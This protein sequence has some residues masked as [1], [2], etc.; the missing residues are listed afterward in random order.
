M[1][2][3]TEDEGIIC[4]LKKPSMGNSSI[5]NDKLTKKKQN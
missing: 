5:C 2:Y 1:L 4:G 3:C